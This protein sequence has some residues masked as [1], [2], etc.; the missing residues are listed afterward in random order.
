MLVYFPLFTFLEGGFRFHRCENDCLPVE[1]GKR[2][3]GAT[4]AESN[5]LQQMLHD[6]TEGF[7]DQFATA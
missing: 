4:A 1:D 3:S 7:T 2:K 5:T 6:L